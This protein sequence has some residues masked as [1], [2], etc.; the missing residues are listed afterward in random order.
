MT[1]TNYDIEAGGSSRGGGALW[2]WIPILLILITG[3]VFSFVAYGHEDLTVLEAITAGFAGVGA[4]IIGVFAGFIGLVVG[5]AGALIGIVA[6][7]GAL[8]LT[9]FL[10]GSPIIAIVLFALLMRRGNSNNC[11]DVCERGEI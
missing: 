11:P 3:G 5:L 9:L 1:S 7:G 4:L 10:V 6:A 2:L 8:A